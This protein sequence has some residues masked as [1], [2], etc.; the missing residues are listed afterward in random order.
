MPTTSQLVQYLQRNGNVGRSN[1]ITADALAIHFNISDA[2]NNNVAMR[3]IITTAINQGELIGS[4]PRGYYI[5]DNLSELDKNLD[6]LQ[7]RAE[8]VLLRRRNM[9]RNW[10][11]INTGRRR[12]TKT[13]LRV[14]P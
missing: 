1:P 3:K 2:G 11:S 10:N 7:R 14:R 12:T 6:S 8:K 9:R 4:S 13:D 5:I